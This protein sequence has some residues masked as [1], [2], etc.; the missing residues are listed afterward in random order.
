MQ[1]WVGHQKAE[2]VISD[3]LNW[4]V[5]L[6]VPQIS[7]WVGSTEN[8]TERP[9]REVKELYKLYFKLLENWERKES[10][11]D[12]YQVKVRFIGDLKKL[13]PKLVGLMGKLMQKTAKYQKKLLNVLINYGGKFELVEVFKKLAA[14]IVKTGKI[15][16]T[17][18]SIEESLLVN[19]PV[20]LVIRTGGFSRLSNFMLWQTS[21]AEMYITKTLLPDF[22]KKEFMK[23]IEWYSSTKRNFGA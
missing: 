5:E 17:E 12:K 2:K 19:S 18:R 1:P 15:E 13:P 9:E 11:L 4:S 10:V 6:G 20:D 14:N 8:L 3:F 22:S 23:A 16:I 7:V 21:Y